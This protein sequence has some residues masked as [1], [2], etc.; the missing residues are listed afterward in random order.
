MCGKFNGWGS[1]KEAN[2]DSE[3]QGSTRGPSIAVETLILSTLT[4][5]TVVSWRPPPDILSVS[6]FYPIAEM[7]GLDD[8]DDD[9]DEDGSEFHCCSDFN[10]IC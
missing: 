5:P 2:P 3:E 7:R 9:F 10:T 4:R 1:T 8:D 6:T